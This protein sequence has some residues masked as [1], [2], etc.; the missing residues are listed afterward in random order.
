MRLGGLGWVV[1]ALAACGDD[2]GGASDPTAGSTSGTGAPTTGVATNHGA[3]DAGEATSDDDTTT[4]DGV[5]APVPLSPTDHLIR[6]SMALRGVRPALAELQQVAE[7]PGAL[8]AIVD[9]Y[10]ADPRFAETVKDIYAEALLMRAQLNQSMLPYVGPLAALELDDASYLASVPEEPLRLIAAIAADP[11]RSW[12]DVV[13]TDEV[14][15]NEVGAAA[16]EVSG[17][18]AQAGGWQTVKWADERR[19]GGGVLNSSAVWH[20]HRSNGNNYQRV[21]ANLVARVFLCEDYLT[22]D[23]PPFPPVDFSDAE[24]LSNALQSNPGCRSCHQTLDP[25]ASY[26]WGAQS[27]GRAGI[28][29]SYDINGDCLPGKE[30]ICYPTEEYLQKQEPGWMVTTERAPGYFGEPTPDGHIDALGEHVAAD[31]RFSQCTARRFYSYMAQVN[32]D[33]VSFELVNAFDAAFQVDGRLDVRALARAIVLS[34]AFKVSHVEDAALAE[35]VVGLK[36][37][38]P[39]QL[40]RM[41]AELTGFR[42]IGM[43]Q[44]D[45]V[46]GEFPLLNSDGWGYRAMAGGIDGYSITQPT[47]TFNPTRTLVVQALAAEAAAYVVDRDFDEPNQGQRKLLQRVTEASSEADVRAQL[48]LL[49]AR[50]LGEMVAADSLEVDESLGLWNAVAGDT[51]RKWKIL[52]TAMFQDNRLVF[53]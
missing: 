13:T 4:A 8:P 47:W 28:A 43:R 29:N 49:H 24:A 11:D 45:D 23:I 25:L 22:R 17:Y 7:D 26:F 32:L 37:A 15:V 46:H 50:V 2:G 36:V 20:R 1:L 40:E 18:D 21:R 33:A 39:E 3:S 10:L 52:L 42:W 9:E 44:P 53:F 41:F 27:R 51:R 5:V 48:A 30:H 16:W 38:R 14:H 19:Q 35:D 12:T 31:P 34:D 6:A